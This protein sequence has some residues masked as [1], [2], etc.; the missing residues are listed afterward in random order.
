MDPLEFENIAAATY[1][2]SRTC[3]LL[4]LNSTGLFST[5]C[6]V[7]HSAEQELYFDRHTCNLHQ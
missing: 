5:L 2:L 1:M 6:C 3:S 4:T 7:L